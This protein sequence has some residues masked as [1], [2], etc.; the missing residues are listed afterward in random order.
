MLDIPATQYPTDNI[1]SFEIHLNFASL[2]YKA[3]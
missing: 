1:K 3:P 2:K